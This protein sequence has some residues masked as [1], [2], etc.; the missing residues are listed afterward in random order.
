MR[1]SARWKRYGLFY[2]GVGDERVNHE[3]AVSMYDKPCDR[4]GTG[5]GGR[6]H[7]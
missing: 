4:G 1:K 2:P 3:V 7:G 6:T 5:E